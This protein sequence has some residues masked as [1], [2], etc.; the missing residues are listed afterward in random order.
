EIYV[1]DP[2]ELAEETELKHTLLLV[3][4]GTQEWNLLVES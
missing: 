3:G 4:I 1:A 2:E